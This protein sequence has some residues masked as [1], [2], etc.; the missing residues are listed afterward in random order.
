MVLLVYLF[1][2]QGWVEIRNALQQISAGHF[3]LALL[4]IFLFALLTGSPALPQ[5]GGELPRADTVVKPLT[6]VSLEPV[7]RGR[8]FEVAVVAEIIPG[9]HINANKV[10]EDYLIPTTIEADPPKGLKVVE[11]VYPKASLQKFEF[12]NAKMA[13][14]DGSVTIRIKLMAEADA[15]LGE[16]TLPVRLRYQACNDKACLPPVRK[17]LSANF[18]VVAAG[19]TAREIHAEIFKKK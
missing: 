13:V 3:V 8:A 17:N 9:F 11:I 2:K 4:L 1:Q 15:P 6:F 19:T 10:L 12:A 14:Y 5:A 16:M 7:P 18:Q